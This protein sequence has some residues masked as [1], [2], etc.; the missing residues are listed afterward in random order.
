LEMY[1]LALLTSG[2][3]GMYSSSSLSMLVYSLLCSEKRKM[4]IDSLCAAG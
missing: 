1:M 4:T 2:F 3:H